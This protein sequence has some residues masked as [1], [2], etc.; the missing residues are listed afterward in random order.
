MKIPL[1]NEPFPGAFPCD[2]RQEGDIT[3]SVLKKSISPQRRKVR[4]E[5]LYRKQLKTL[6]SLRLCGEYGLGACRT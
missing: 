5:I 4:K 3:V 1:K 6:R 2:L